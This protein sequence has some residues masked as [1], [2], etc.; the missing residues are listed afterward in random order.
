MSS[1]FHGIETAKRSLFTQMA[2]LNTTGQNIANANTPGFSRQVVNMSASIPMEAMAMNRSNTPGQLGT[3]VEVTSITRV[4]QSFLDDQFRNEN[5]SLGNWS[6]QSDTLDKLQSI[7]NEPSDSGLSKVLNNFWSSWSDLSKDPEN[8]TGRKIVSENTK[9]LTDALNQTSKQL[10][11]LS[12]DLTTNI[13]VKTTEINST[14]STI[15]NLNSE[16]QRIEGLGDNANDL[17]D[18]RDLLTDN[19]SKIANIQVTN[20]PQ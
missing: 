6:I 11:D 19:L 17:R 20:T 13:Q 2:A 5:N 18:Q 10:S 12:N 3:G 16:I 8:A 7:I 14:V 9:A 1:T 4:R 15:A